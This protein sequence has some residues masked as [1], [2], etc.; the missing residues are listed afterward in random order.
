MKDWKKRT[1]R[2]LLPGIFVMIA[3]LVITVPFFVK[4]KTEKNSRIPKG[5]YAGEIYIGEMTKEEAALLVKEFMT[6]IRDR[7]ITLKAGNHRLET[8]AGELG[9]L[10]DNQEIIEEAAGLGTTGNLI[11]RYKELKDL[12]QDDKVYDI[13]YAMNQDAVRRLLEEN[14]DTLNTESIDSKLERKENSFEITLGSQGIDVDIEKSLQELENFFQTEWN[15]SDATID[16]AVN[17]TEP[18][19]TKEELERVKDLLGTYQTSYSA[20]NEGRRQNIEN[21]TS[22]I[23]GIVVY[24]DEVFSVYEVAHPFEPE[25]GY[26]IGGAY[27]NGMVVDSYGGGICQVSTTLYNAVIRAELE[28]VERFPHSMVVTYVEPSEDAAIAG[29]YKDLKFKNNTNTPIYLEGYT[30]GGVL[31][32]NIYGEETREANRK[33]TF[34]SEILSTTEP[35]VRFQAAGD[36]PI[37]YIGVEQTEHVGYKAQLLKIVTVDGVEQSREIFN[38]STYNSSARI[39]AVGT[40][41]GNP[42]AVAVIN[43][44]V[45]T[46]DQETIYTAVAQWNEIP[47]PEQPQ[48]EE[49]Q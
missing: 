46:Q 44:A 37:G 49:P 16:L 34:E 27:E 38:T 48:P 26:A 1:I 24:P 41:S 28:V 25:N 22:K 14:Q 40:A 13:A 4:A 12:E 11:E 42:E 7:K 17:I 36:K 30:S 32:F 3:I 9:I 2:Y 8:T 10:W 20:S 19:G 5:V 21:G 43:G 15:G 6:G 45:G 18:K 29:T 31:H 23:N 47:Q 33:V 39:M 35:G